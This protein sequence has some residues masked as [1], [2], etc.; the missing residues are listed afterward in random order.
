[1]IYTDMKNLEHYK[2]IGK[3]LD[4]AIDY[5]RNHDLSELTP[6]RN[7][8]DGDFVFINR[9]AYDTMAEEKAAF[10]AHER[11][12]DIHLAVSG[13]EYIGVSD[14]SLM[15]VTAVDKETDSVGCDGIVENR[16]VMKPGKVLIVLPE[17]AHK[18]KIAI[19][20]SVHMEKAVV[21]VL[22]NQE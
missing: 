2:G 15:T 20:D 6:G 12:A 19:D 22:V 10:E 21:K 3:H 8:V 1:M 18:V 5:L 7:E 9:F 4:T 17:D 16:V 13:E 11:Y 14:M